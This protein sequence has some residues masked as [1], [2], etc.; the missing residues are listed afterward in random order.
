MAKSLVRAFVLGVALSAVTVGP[1]LA[2]KIPP[3]AAALDDLLPKAELPG[4][5]IEK[6]KALRVQIGQLAAAGQSN[7]AREVEEQAMQ[8]LGYRKAWLRC[9]PG[10]FT[11]MKRRRA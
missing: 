4:P 10:T 3:L 9:G 7:E 8:I 11:W 6:I 1:A 5:E 2:C